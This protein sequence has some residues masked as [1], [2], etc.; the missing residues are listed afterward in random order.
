M[1]IFRPKKTQSQLALPFQDFDFQAAH[2]SV[3][4]GILASVH[5]VNN[6]SVKILGLSGDNW[7]IMDEITTPGTQYFGYTHD[8]YG[9]ILVIGDHGY[10]SFRGRVSIYRFSG[11]S[12]NLQQHIISPTPVSFNFFGYFVRVWGSRIIISE[13]S[14]EGTIRVYEESGGVWS[15]VQ[16]ISGANSSS[17][18]GECLDIVS[19]VLVA[20]CSSPGSIFIY[21]HDGE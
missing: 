13:F 2:I 12:W 14:P 5:D 16:T 9:D 3:Y 4:N 11:G 10:N 21:R 18:L 17:H 15:V 7:S 19:D 20:S 6:D 8:I 1:I